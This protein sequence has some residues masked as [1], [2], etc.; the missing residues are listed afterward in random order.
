MCNLIY[1]ITKS[2]KQYIYMLYKFGECGRYESF[3]T[4][5]SNR[6]TE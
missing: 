1:N 5:A 2:Y 3:P 6:H 4:A